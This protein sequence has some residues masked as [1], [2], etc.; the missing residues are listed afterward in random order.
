[1]NV[2][3]IPQRDAEE[4]FTIHI[5]YKDGR[6]DIL[7]GT[8]GVDFEFTPTSYAIIDEKED[9]LVVQFNSINSLRIIKE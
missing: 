4:T 1:M 2:V 9:C 5:G 8:K 7:N 3:D 6:T